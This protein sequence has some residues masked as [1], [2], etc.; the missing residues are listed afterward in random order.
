MDQTIHNQSYYTSVETKNMSGSNDL[1]ELD[2]DG[3][4]AK[5][6]TKSEDEV[7]DDSSLVRRAIDQFPS[8][9]NMDLEEGKVPIEQDRQSGGKRT[10]YSSKKTGSPPLKS[11]VSFDE[12]APEVHHLDDEQEERANSGSG[13]LS[14]VSK[15]YDIDGDGKLGGFVLP[16]DVYNIK[17]L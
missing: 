10:A 16:C 11:R 2:E 9:S 13:R 12:D 15:M 3:A 1:V 7:A 6:A 17:I 5:P 8:D 4:A 14:M